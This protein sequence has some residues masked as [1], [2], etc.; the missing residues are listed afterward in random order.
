[1]PVKESGGDGVTLESPLDCELDETSVVCLSDF[2]KF[3]NTYVIEN[4]VSALGR[5]IYYWGG[6]YSNI[7]DGNKLHDNGGV[8]MEDLSGCG[9]TWNCAGEIFGQILNNRVTRARGFYSNSAM[10]G[11]L[12]GETHDSTITV[13]IRGNIAEDDCTFTALPR[14]SHED[15]RHELPRRSI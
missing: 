14:R 13:V 3:E 6:T 7:V 10:I 4:E 8:L 12:G 2:K 5:G 15:G 11:L 9:P 1:M